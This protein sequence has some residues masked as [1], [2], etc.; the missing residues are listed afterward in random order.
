MAM[1][2]PHKDADTR[3]AHERISGLEQMFF[4]HLEGHNLIE[5]AIIENTRITKEIAQNT[6]DIVAFF[7]GAKG[8]R[9]FILWASPVV[10][11]GMAVWAWLKLQLLP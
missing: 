10:I 11:I 8:L 2:T 7:S 6:K 5:Q 1:E 3:R 9:T 4:E